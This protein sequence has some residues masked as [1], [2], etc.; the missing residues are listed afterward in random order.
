MTTASCC[1]DEL[2][3][4]MCGMLVMMVNDNS[5]TKRRTI[6]PDINSEDQVIRSTGAE[7]TSSSD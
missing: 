3:P 6:K 1:V 2:A 7:P 5:G 4:P